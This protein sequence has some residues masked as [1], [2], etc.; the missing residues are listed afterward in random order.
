MKPKN[1]DSANFLL[2]YHTTPIPRINIQNII[3]TSCLY[4]NAFKILIIISEIQI[5]TK[6]KNI[7][8]HLILNKYDKLLCS[9]VIF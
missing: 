7:S 6:N 5:D 4:Q 9:I 3:Q 8:A 1:K 2:L